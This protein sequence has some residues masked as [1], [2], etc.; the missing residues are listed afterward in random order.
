MSIQG[1]FATATLPR[2][3]TTPGGGLPVRTHASYSAWKYTASTLR[4]STTPSPRGLPKDHFPPRTGHS[5]K[6][7]GA[8]GKSGV[9]GQT[10]DQKGSIA[11]GPLI[12][13]ERHMLPGRCGWA[14]EFVVT[15]RR[16]DAKKS[17]RPIALG[18]AAYV[19]FIRQNAAVTAR[20]AAI[21]SPHVHMSGF[22]SAKQYARTRSCG[23]A[24]QGTSRRGC[25]GP[26]GCVD[27]CVAS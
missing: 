6:E 24:I 8:R 10:R 12:K 1:V 7:A 20:A 13:G 2:P 18:S 11:V 5:T 19:V 22:P 17:S 15:Q 14:G 26:C 27:G 21:T 4:R 23:R 25:T 9:G 3:W 16:A